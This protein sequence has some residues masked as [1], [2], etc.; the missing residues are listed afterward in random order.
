MMQ[1]RLLILIFLATSLSCKKV[2]I[3]TSNKTSIQKSS[4]EIL[5]APLIV[6]LQKGEGS[7]LAELKLSFEGQ[8]K[9]AIQLSEQKETVQNLVIQ[10]VSEF[11]FESLN[12]QSGKQSFQKQLLSSI[13]E[14][15]D[16]K[17]FE[18][19]NIIEIKEI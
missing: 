10:T 14:F 6:R 5:S 12:S 3:P 17:S 8:K 11:S 13:N 7:V 4:T 9:I 2:S 16:N 15:V 19:I 18:K 1:T